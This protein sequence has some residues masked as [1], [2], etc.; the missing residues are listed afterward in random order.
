V[1]EYPVVVSRSLTLEPSSGIVADDCLGPARFRQWLGARHNRQSIP[2]HLVE[3]IRR[4][5]VDGLRHLKR[6]DTLWQVLD[7]VGEIRYFADHRQEP[8]RVEIF[9]IQSER[10]GASK[11]AQAGADR[12]AAW[13][14]T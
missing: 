9:L 2:D 10:P 5:V 8:Y 13:M 14:S 3:A 1:R 7:G 6:G 12:L 11:I 4:P